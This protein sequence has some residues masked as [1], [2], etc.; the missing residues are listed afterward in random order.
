M[1]EFLDNLSNKIAA[2]RHNGRIKA[3]RQAFETYLVNIPTEPSRRTII[4]AMLIGLMMG[5]SIVWGIMGVK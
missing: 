1:N 2:D 4:G 5:A 3:I